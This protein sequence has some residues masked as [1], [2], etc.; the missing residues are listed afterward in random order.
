MQKFST[1]W[2]SIQGYG[3][4]EFRPSC[5]AFTMSFALLCAFHHSVLI[6]AARRLP[7]SL[8][9]VERPSLTIDA[10]RLESID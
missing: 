3:I 5:S 10:A 4:R 6:L 7:L 1:D 2:H 9:S 8:E